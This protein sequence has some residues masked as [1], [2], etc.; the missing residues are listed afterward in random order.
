MYVS[1]NGKIMEANEAKVSPLSQGFLY[2]YGLFETIKAINGKLY[3]FKEHMKRMREGSGVLNFEFVYDEDLVYKNCME[4]LEKNELRDG[5]VRLSYSKDNN[6]Y[7]LFINTRENVYTEE[8]YDNGFELCFAHIKRNPHSSTVYLK[9]N[10]YL[11]SILERQRAKAKG[12]DEAIFFNIYD[13]LCEGTISNIFFI[14]DEKIFTP[15]IKCG[16]L[17]GIIRNKAIEIIKALNLK[18]NIG[19]YKRE[20]IIT[21]DEIFITNSLMDIMPVSRLEEKKLNIENNYITRTLMK[22]IKKIYNG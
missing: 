14:K 8:S 12:F 11:E 20:N 22:E 5:A 7:I 19:E 1:L 16:I 21:S 10:N 18:V 15:D 3:F 4:L 13:N 17:S 2:G 9:S 6:R